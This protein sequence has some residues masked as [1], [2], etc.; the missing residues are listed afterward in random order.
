M[1]HGSDPIT[2]ALNGPFIGR[3]LRAVLYCLAYVSKTYHALRDR[4]KGVPPSP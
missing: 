3:P 1:T 4:T 2:D